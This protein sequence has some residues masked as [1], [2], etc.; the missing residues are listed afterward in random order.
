MHDAGLKR[1][2]GVKWP[3]CSQSRVEQTIDVTWRPCLLATSALPLFTEPPETSTVI[4]QYHGR[5]N[6][7][8]GLL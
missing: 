7:P 4:A 8:I 3:K 6:Q 1:V 5:S 2:G